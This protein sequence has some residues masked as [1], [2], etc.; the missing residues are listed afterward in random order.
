MRPYLKAWTAYTV[1]IHQNKTLLDEMMAESHP[2]LKPNDSTYIGY[3]KKLTSRWYGE[4]REIRHAEWK[5]T[6]MSWNTNG[7]PPEAQQK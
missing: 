1:A 3:R 5:D 2:G 4:Q 6:A 7:P